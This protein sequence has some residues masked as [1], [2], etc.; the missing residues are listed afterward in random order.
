MKQL[1]RPCEALRRSVDVVADDRP[2][3]C[4]AVNPKLVSA[5]SDRFEGEPGERRPV[6]WLA[7]GVRPSSPEG[8][9]RDCRR[10]SRV[11]RRRCRVP[12]GHPTLRRMRRSVRWGCGTAVTPFR[13]AGAGRPSQH[14][15]R[16][17]RRQP[18]G[19]RLHPPA[20][21][22]VKPAQG[23]FDR[24]LVGVGAALDHGPISLAHLAVLE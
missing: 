24:A 13:P 6:C 7:V 12:Y 3:A 23:Q 11:G 14:L 1:W 4:R 18:V 8:G 17:H 21:P 19:I 22:L 16:G 2:P 20:P 5:A 10:Q 15:P 9:G